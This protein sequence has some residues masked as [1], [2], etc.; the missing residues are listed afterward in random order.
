MI[1]AK[2]NKEE[3]ILAITS[4]K[5]I[6]EKKQWKSNLGTHLNLLLLSKS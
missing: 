2:R 1:K 4:Y 5:Y 3:D 6:I